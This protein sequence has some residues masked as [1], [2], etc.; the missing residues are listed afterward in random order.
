MT[1]VVGMNIFIDRQIMFDFKANTFSAVAS[2][3]TPAGF[4]NVPVE[5]RMGTF[6]IADIEIDGV[7]AKAIVDTGARITVVNAKLQSALGFKDNDAR[8]TVD[9]PLGGASADLTAA[10]KGT[11]GRIS[12][13]GVTFDK[14][15][16]DFTDLSVFGALGLGNEPTLLLGIDQL[17]QLQGLAIDYP[18]SELRLKP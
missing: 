7:K 17:H 11:L 1:E 8:L 9:K 6:V 14:P 3:T 10:K 2:S 18:K 13:G 12:L 4:R 16:V 15:S 5:M